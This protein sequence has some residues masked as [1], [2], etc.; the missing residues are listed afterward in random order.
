MIKSIIKIVIA[1][2]LANA[3]WRVASAYISYYKFQDAVQEYAIRTSGKS[4]DT[5]KSRVAELA[6]QYEEPVDADAISVTR[7]EQHT[8]IEASYT[9]P[10]AV[11]PGYEYQWPF[12]VKV[13]GYVIDPQHATEP[14]PAR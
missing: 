2:L 6:A 11:L 5:V 13:D 4:D 10:V 7:N 12:S 1:V 14:A 8:F 9:K 3:I